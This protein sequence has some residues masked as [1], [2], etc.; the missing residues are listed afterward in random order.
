MKKNVFIIVL[1]AVTTYSQAQNKNKVVLDM[2]QNAKDSIE[3]NKYKGASGILDSALVYGVFTDSILY[4]RDIMR[5]KGIAF[6]Y[7]LY[8]K[9]QFDSSLK[10]I[11]DVMA[12]DVNTLDSYYWTKNAKNMSIIKRAVATVKLGSMVST[13]SQYVAQN[14]RRKISKDTYI[15][16]LQAVREV[17]KKGDDKVD[18]DFLYPYQDSLSNKWGFNDS[19]NILL[20]PCEYDEIVQPFETGIAIVKKNGI[21]GFLDASGIST[22][23]NEGITDNSI[24]GHDKRSNKPL[25]AKEMMEL[26]QT[27]ITY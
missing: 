1:F 10:Y 9:R 11:R 24:Y 23:D 2:L 3:L 17:S 25:N 16:I 27:E 15:K 19:H 8:K 18:T 21:Y 12:D 4:W 13:F 7:E 22:F 26:I 6:S 5:E 14:V 20:I